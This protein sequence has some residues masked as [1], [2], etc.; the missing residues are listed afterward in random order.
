MKCFNCGCETNEYLCNNCMTEDILNIIFKQLLL[1]KEENCD[2]KYI[3]EYS[4]TLNE[5]KD[6]INCIPTILKK[7]DSSINGYYY[8]RYYKRV[9]DPLF[10]QKAI[11]YLNL[12]ENFDEKKQL[13]LY[14]LLNFYLRDDY[15]KPNYWCNII[16][17]R[18][19]LCIE[20]YAISSEYFSMV[21]DY[22]LSEKAIELGTE[23]LDDESN[24]L[25][26][27][28]E[29]M[30]KSFEKTKSLLIRYKSGKP[31]WPATEER[32]IKVAKIYDE[33][34]INYQINSTGERRNHNR[35]D[36]RIKASDFIANNEWYDDI[37][38]DY[39]SFWCSGIYSIKTVITLYEIG[40]VKVSNGKIIEKFYDVVKPW[41]DLKVKKQAANELGIT[42]EELNNADSVK[43]AMEKF[44]Q[45]IGDD[46]I[47]STEG[48]GLQKNILTRAMRYA[49]YKELKNPIGDI[50]DYAADKDSK[51]D[52]ENNNRKYL[53]DYF[54]IEEGKNA[55]DKAII[56]YEIIEKLRKL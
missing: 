29:Y 19:D 32:R 37:P 28:K 21:G 2:N 50:L 26:S 12:H 18:N 20:L 8:C 1:T 3:L 38:N 30:N 53:L 11:E 49:F 27:N 54:G 13:V 31:Y 36:R 6:I 56:N 35:E 7:F 46:L 47:V 48:L 14:D 17:N 15:E 40:A 51:F 4:Q 9:N 52:F 41:E 16:I 45:F 22:D 43:I 55:L 33:K 44:S 39:I 5:F 24:Y 25:F 42:I 23:K 10:E 34:G